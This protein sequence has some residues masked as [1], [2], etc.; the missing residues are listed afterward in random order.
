[1][2]PSGAVQRQGR[3][4]LNKSDDMEDI[5]EKDLSGAMVSPDE[6]GYER[7][8]G[9][10]FDTMRLAYELNEGYHTP[11]EVRDYRASRDGRW[12]RR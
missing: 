5:F 8:I 6:P 1:M 11:E 4:C 3:N 12:M 10:I 2:G 9:R 7:L